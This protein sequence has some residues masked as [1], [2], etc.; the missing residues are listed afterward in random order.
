MGTATERDRVAR[1]LFEQ[2]AA[3][4]GYESLTWDSPALNHE[5]FYDRA[6]ELLE[7]LNARAPK[8]PLDQRY[9]LDD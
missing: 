1:Q 8:T 7:V 2:Q 9:E 6:D 4:Y 3:K 5:T